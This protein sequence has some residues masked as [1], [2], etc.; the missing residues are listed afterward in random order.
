L[1]VAAFWTT[2]DFTG[3]VVRSWTLDNFRTLLTEHVYTTITLRT[4]GVA[5]LVTVVDVII[6]FPM[7]RSTWR[8]FPRPARSDCWSSPS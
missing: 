3:Q 4:V 7:A 2:D 6:A 5:A 1:F 8:R